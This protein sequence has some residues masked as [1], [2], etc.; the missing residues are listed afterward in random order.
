MS[1]LDT[2][3]LRP[4][5]TLRQSIEEWKD[6][7]TMITIASMK[8]KLLLEEEE[9][10][11]HCLKQ[12]QDLCEQR[13]LHREWVVLENYIPV[14]IELLSGKNRDIRNHALFILCILAKDSDDTKERI[15]KVDNAV[16][17]IVRFLGRR[18]GERKLA[19]TLL[20]ELSR[21]ESVRDCIGKVQGC[22]LLLVTMSSCDDIQAARDASELLE[23]LSFSDQNVIQMAKANYFKH[24]LLRLSSGPEDVQMN[25]AKTLAEMELTDH[26]KSSL[27]EEG[28]LGSLLHLVSYSDIEMKEVAVKAL[29]NLSS[30]PRNGRQMIREGAV[31]ILLDLLCRHTSSPSLREQQSI[32]Q[33][34]HAMCQSPSATNIKTNLTQC[35]A[36]QVLVQ[37]CEFDNLNVRANAVKLFCC[38]TEDGNEA[39]ITI[40]EHL[41]K[42][43]IETLLK[44]IRTSNDEE[45]IAS[46]MGIIS[47]L[48]KSLQITEWLLDAEGLP[49]I[50]N[51]L[52]DGK[53][54]GP[55]KNQ[56]IENA[57][58]AICHFTVPTNQQSQKKAAEAGVIPVLFKSVRHS[59]AF[60]APPVT[61]C[62]VHR[63][64]CTVASSFC[65]VEADAV[66]PL[67][68]VLGEQDTGACEASLDALLTLIE[69][70]RLQ[71]GSKVL[72]EAKAITPIIQ[73][74][75]SPSPRLQE[76]VLS[77]LE[78][79]FRLL[80]FKQKYGAS[81]QMFLVDLTRSGNS[82][83]KSLAAKILAH[84]NVL[85]EQS[86]YF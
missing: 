75:S 24:L 18:I 3:I 1:P 53:H 31:S 76:K 16:E 2:S 4:N 34:F 8:P 30:L 23:N 17:S 14:L 7:N 42:K 80:E 83:T 72:A 57:V 37:L 50:F 25:M 84:L 59:G 77:S 67:V 73:L 46:A 41:E 68:R 6:R 85:H 21:S 11:L 48:P 33:A 40:L 10:V 81:A 12:L 54:N 63:G 62:P 86:S 61:G 74:L 71:S 65:L 44:I 19:V 51:F 39:F 28:V 5:R 82:S 58:G 70:E 56:L 45:E 69:G 27:L 22:I 35:S 9:E 43:S 29:H 49:I 32:L 55:H 13:D 47:N 26:N 52:P 38:L 78:R 15:A 20:L 79:I 60:H 36:V 66:E 64:I